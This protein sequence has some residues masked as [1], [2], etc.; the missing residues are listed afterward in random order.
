MNTQLS[1]RVR[2]LSK[3]GLVL[4]S[5]GLLLLSLGLLLQPAGLAQA[6]SLTEPLTEAA[7]VASTRYVAVEG[8]DTG[9]DCSISA[10]PCATIQW[11]VDVAAPDDEIRVAA[12]TYTGVQVRQ[13]ITQVVYIS[14]S[15]T[16]RG[17]YTTTNWMTSD[18]E[19]NAT[20]LD[21]QGQ[22]RV[23]VILYVQATL[24]D[25]RITGGDTQSFAD[26]SGGSAG[27][28]GGGLYIAAVTT[29]SDC[30]IYSNTATYFG[31]GL[32]AHSSVIT[33][34]QSRI[35]SNSLSPAYSV[36]GGIYAELG[37]SFVDNNIVFDNNAVYGGGVYLGFGSWGGRLSENQI[38]S[39]RAFQR[40]GGLLLISTQTPDVLISRN[41]FSQ[42]VAGADGG[43]AFLG[44]GVS[45]V[46]GNLFIS[47]TA[48][49]VGGGAHVYYGSATLMRNTFL[50]NTSSVGGGGVTIISG[51]ATLIENYFEHNYA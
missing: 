49:G 24:E 7:P 41:V 8:T 46:T 30:R 29:I 50:S 12:G 13:G 44:T 14:Q 18:P 32:Y 6:W 34:T 21:A 11:A 35:F 26:L 51:S 39:N 17:G 9:N 16:I 2:P 4:G 37:T 15:V 27:R 36:G 48:T 10:T 31:G 33:V 28:V 47:N 1:L 40:G 22:G 43:G 5:S 23:I 45:V 38:Y 19:T 3:I 20:I 25:L 42:N